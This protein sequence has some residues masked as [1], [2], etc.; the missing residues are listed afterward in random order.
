MKSSKKPASIGTPTF[1]DH[2]DVAAAGLGAVVWIVI[3]ELPLP[4]ETVAEENVQV[5]SAGN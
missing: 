3:V 4:D 2:T 5:V 1:A